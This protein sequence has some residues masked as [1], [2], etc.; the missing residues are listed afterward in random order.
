MVLTADDV[1]QIADPSPAFPSTP[2]LGLG[3]PP[4]PLLPA[5][6]SRRSP[7]PLPP[8]FFT[9]P[10]STKGSPVPI[11]VR[12]SGGSTPAD[13]ATVRRLNLAL[14]DA[15][16]GRRRPAVAGQARRGHRADQGDGVQPGH[17]ADRPRPGDRGHHRSQR[18]GRPAGPSS[19]IPDGVRFLGIELQVDYIAGHGPGPRRP[20]A[21][22]PPD[23]PFDGELGPARALGVVARGLPGS[24]H[25]RGSGS[26]RCRA[27]MWRCPG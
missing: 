18:L 20:G 25:G 17:R 22:P 9:Q 24:G 2:D 6:S 3:P 26:I 16:P 4:S 5:R 11:A 19:S 8:N 23:R 14:S 13:Q 7:D 12:P 10:H 27:C 15:Q 1:R 21:R